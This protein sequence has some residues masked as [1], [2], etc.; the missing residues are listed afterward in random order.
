MLSLFLQNSLYAEESIK[1]NSDPHYNDIGFFDIHICNWPERSNF[2]KI[3]FSSEKYDEIESMDVY[4][5]DN[6]LLISLD[7]TKFRHLKRKNK[8]NKKVFMLEIDVP[9]SASTGWYSIDVRAKD[10]STYQV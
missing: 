5:P 2:F 6:K 7:K 9:N 1:F 4:T 10:G 3:L 8:P